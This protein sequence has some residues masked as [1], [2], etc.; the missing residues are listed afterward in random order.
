M[1]P[2]AIR[3][4]IL[5]RK[6]RHSNRILHRM[7][8]QGIRKKSCL[9]LHTWP[10]VLDKQVLPNWAGTTFIII[11]KQ[12]K[13]CSH[14]IAYPFSSLNTTNVPTLG[15]ATPKPTT[16]MFLQVEQNH[17]ER[18]PYIGAVIILAELQSC[19]IGQNLTSTNQNF[20]SCD[21][22][23]KLLLVEIH[24]HTAPNLA[25][26]L[27]LKCHMDRRSQNQLPS[28]GFIAISCLQEVVGSSPFDALSL[29]FLLFTQL[30]LEGA[31][32]V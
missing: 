27:W 23:E 16:A 9:L 18:K 28:Y 8:K 19:Q 17:V 2:F 32:G 12:Y 14:N 29:F 31:L 13:M 30:K 6:N 11:C 4:D 24:T 25:I 5:Q 21:S 3:R 20:G 15:H 1:L 26:R 10:I 22:S 7:C